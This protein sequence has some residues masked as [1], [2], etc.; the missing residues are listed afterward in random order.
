MPIPDLPPLPSIGK[1]GI[2]LFGGETDA[3]R[4]D[5]AIFDDPE[6]TWASAQWRDVTPES[7][8]VEVKW[9]ADDPQGILTVPAGSIWQVQTY[10]PERK[11]D[12]TNGIS[13]YSAA[14]KPGHP[15][16]VLFKPE[17][18]EPWTVR[19]GFIDE[20]E[21]DLNTKTGAVRG[22][23]AVQLLVGARL[24]EGQELDTKMPTTL[25]AR[26]NYLINKAKLQ[27]IIKV[28]GYRD[29]AAIVRELRPYRWYRCDEKFVTDPMLDR[30]GQKGGNGYYSGESGV[31]K[32]RQVSLVADQNK[33]VWLDGWSSV[34]V[35]A[36]PAAEWTLAFWIRWDDTIKAASKPGHNPLINDLGGELISYGDILVWVESDGTFRVGKNDSEMSAYY[37]HSEIPIPRDTLSHMI[38]LQESADGLRIW[39]DGQDV[40]IQDAA[41]VVEPKTTD[42][43]IGLAS[44]T[45][46]NWIGWCG[47]V[48]EITAYDRLLNAQDFGA[49]YTF[50]LGL[51]GDYDPP[52]GPVI[53]KEAT[54]WAH[55]TT[56]AYD[57]LYAV[58]MDRLN[59]LRFR[60]FGQPRSIGLQIGGLLG[61]GIDTVVVGSSMQGV[62]TRVV[63]YDE[64]GY[65]P[66]L[67]VPIEA[68]DLEKQK[69][70]GDIVLHRDHPVPD[71]QAWVDAIL[72][73]RAGASL[74]L[75][76]GTIRPQTDQDMIDLLQ[77]GMMDE[78]NLVV[79]SAIP[80]VNVNPLILGGT[81]RADTQS[82]WSA[83]VVSYIPNNEWNDLRGPEP[84]PWDPSQPSRYEW[85][86]YLATKSARLVQTPTANAGN[87][88]SA[89]I[90]VGAFGNKNRS[91]VLLQF[92]T[93]D[94]SDVI[95]I[96]TA[97]L[98]LWTGTQHCIRYGKTPKIIVRRT[99]KGWNEGTYGV[100][101]GWSTTNAVVYPGP[102]GTQQGQVTKGGLPRTN[103]T[104]TTTVI[105]AI[106]RAWKNGAPQFGLKIV[107]VGEDNPAYSHE[108]H[109][110]HTG[111][112]DYIPQLRVRVRVPA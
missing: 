98:R 37:Y 8:A 97:Q 72:L 111:T 68:V 39:M 109:G 87:G 61:Q 9:G 64:E 40:T 42:C 105:P 16:R 69:L 88:K 45:L 20:I 54:V 1:I 58:W 65:N 110:A 26:A 59:V 57:A 21:F 93:I 15:F 60:S 32:M 95:G 23:D 2:E 90:Q 81:F 85:R 71:A 92:P 3:D 48:D 62:F 4:W 66:D 25:R 67:P 112:P 91:R 35:P 77:L 83:Q 7:A 53:E 13:G 75:V 14:L 52:V 56:A 19:H 12:P 82:G 22:S 41:W 43:T 84:P 46:S 74:Q 6:A 70:Y 79:E 44:P 47:Y 5:Q 10:D 49:L 96:D 78:I 107:A 50:G 30:S 33:S 28:E 29:W 34:N 108:F 38:A 94:F 36:F 18:G 86:T 104:M 27:N 80:E 73:D 17:N 106:V 63:S 102:Q 76:P 89:L 101:C 99:L 55:I 31:P 24:P 100:D 103:N 11:L 51:D